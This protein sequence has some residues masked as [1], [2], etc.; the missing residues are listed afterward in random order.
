LPSPDFAEGRGGKLSIITLCKDWEKKKRKKKEKGL[1]DKKEKEGE[2]KDERSPQME[3]G[4][5]KKKSYDGKLWDKNGSNLKLKE[6]EKKTVTTFYFLKKK[7]EKKGAGLLP[8]EKPTWGKKKNNKGKI[9][10]KLHSLTLGVSGEK[11]RRGLKNR[12]GRGRHHPSQKGERKGR[13]ISATVKSLR[14]KKKK[15]W[16]KKRKKKTKRKGKKS[17]PIHV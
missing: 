4:G 13:S 12:R 8:R 5:K 14:E 17:E 15:S 7:G 16:K 10:R 1:V 3:E 6:E 2:G 9:K 11:K